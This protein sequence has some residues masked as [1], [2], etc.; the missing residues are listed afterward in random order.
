SAQNQLRPAVD[1]HGQFP[2]P[3]ARGKNRQGIHHCGL[4]SPVPRLYRSKRHGYHH[5]Q[6]RRGRLWKTRSQ[7]LVARRR[8]SKHRARRAVVGRPKTQ[9][10]IRLTELLAHR[11][12]MGIKAR[13]TGDGTFKCRYESSDITSFAP[14]ALPLED[15]RGN[16]GGVSGGPVFRIEDSSDPF[17]FVGVMSEVGGGTVDDADTVVIDAVDGVPSKFS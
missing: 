17:V 9:N 11:P 2:L 1:P 12:A 10:L 8:L 6:Y 5:R 14:E 15:L 7:P 3:P 16:T 4:K 13:S